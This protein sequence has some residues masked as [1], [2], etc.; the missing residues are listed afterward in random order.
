MH[1]NPI[2][3]FFSS[4]KLT[5]FTLFALA[6]TSI[7]GTVIPQDLPKA[8]YIN[9][10]KP[11]TY[12]ILNFFGIF[13]MYHSWWFLALLALLILN[14]IFC[15]LKHYKTTYNRVFKENIILTPAIE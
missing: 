6:L 4:L 2:V 1:S 13:D 8:Q 5:L 15:S 9:H 12:K 14:L 7:I 11:A 10:F 3:K